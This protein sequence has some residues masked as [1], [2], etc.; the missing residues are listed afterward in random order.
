M[1]LNVLDNAIADSIKVKVASLVQV[2]SQFKRTCGAGS[3]G[4]TFS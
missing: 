2:A 1:R 3:K 4:L